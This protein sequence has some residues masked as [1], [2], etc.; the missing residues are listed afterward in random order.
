ML[1]ASLI[2]RPIQQSGKQATSKMANTTMPPVATFSSTR[3]GCVEL[4]RRQ[5]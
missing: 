4:Q 3:A 1:C 2:K 5:L